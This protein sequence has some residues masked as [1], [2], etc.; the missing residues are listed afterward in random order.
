M[1]LARTGS[2]RDE[3]TM[4]HGKHIKVMGKGISALLGDVDRVEEFLSRLV[5]E[6]GMRML[7]SPAIHDVDLDLERMNVVPFM[8]EGGITGT[9]VLSTSH[10]AIHTW[11]ARH[12]FVLDCFSCRDYPTDVVLSALFRA[13]GTFTV[14]VV[15]VDCDYPD[16]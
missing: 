15:D 12:V 16:F 14:K 13:F 5:K 3:S 9:V 8:D 1:P 2:V 11:P 6:L 7:G 4:N 10:I